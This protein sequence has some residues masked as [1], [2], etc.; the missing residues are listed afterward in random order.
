[1]LPMSSIDPE[2]AAKNP[3]MFGDTGIPAFF[4]GYKAGAKKECLRVSVGRRRVIEAETT[5]STSEAA[6]W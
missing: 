6:T 3:F 5:A 4:G 1:M 2:K